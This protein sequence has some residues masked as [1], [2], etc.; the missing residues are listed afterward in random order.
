MTRAEEILSNNSQSIGVFQELTD[1]QDAIGIPNAVPMILDSMSIH[2]QEFA[3]WCSGNDWEFR[4][5]AWSLFDGDYDEIA[6]RSTSELYTL[7][8][9]QNK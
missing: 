1:L 9:N 6:I 7:F 4:N 3:E 8:N 5:G 2:A